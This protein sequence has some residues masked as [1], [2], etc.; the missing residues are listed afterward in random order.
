M[1]QRKF[2]ALCPVSDE[3]YLTFKDSFD[4]AKKKKTWTSKTDN[5]LMTMM[6]SIYLK[7]KILLLLSQQI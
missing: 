3:C 6:N 1:D 7:V 4:S 2:Q 5:K